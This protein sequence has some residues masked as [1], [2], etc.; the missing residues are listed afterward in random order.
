[1]NQAEEPPVSRKRVPIWPSHSPRRPEVRTVEMMS[2]I[3]PEG[4][5]FGRGGCS[6]V[7]VVVVEKCRDARGEEGD[8]EVGAGPKAPSRASIW[9][10]IRHLMSS[11]GVL[12]HSFSS[13]PNRDEVRHEM[14]NLQDEARDCSCSSC[15]QR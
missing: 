11:I 8:D 2:E 5:I 7:V 10:C 1:V 15:G 13:K 12:F 14:E 6:G 9:T 4:G 3:G